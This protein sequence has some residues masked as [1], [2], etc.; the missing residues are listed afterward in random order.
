MI[1]YIFINLF[2][3]SNI[4][5]GLAIFVPLLFALLIN[6]SRMKKVYITGCYSYAIIG[7]VIGCK[8]FGILENILNNRIN[9]L[10]Y[11]NGF[12]GGITGYL[13]IL[14]LYKLFYKNTPQKIFYILIL[15]LPSIYGIAK[16]NCLY[17]NC[18][19]GTLEVPLQL[20]ESITYLLIFLG[21][22]I[23]YIKSYNFKFSYL[24]LVLLMFIRFILDF[25]RVQRDILFV[26]LTL[27][28]IFCIII[29]I[30]FIKRVISRN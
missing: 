14:K 8:I 30:I 11:G 7:L 5:I 1:K 25:F 26:N 3:I 20:I 24:S 13:C 6:I 17:S 22:Y 28:Q 23:L 4:I 29:I 21:C 18:C 27:A 19:T 15:L 10:L 2:S 16:I 9:L 12:L